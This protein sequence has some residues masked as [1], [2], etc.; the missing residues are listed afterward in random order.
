LK[1]DGATI[2]LASRVAGLLHVADHLL[3]LRRGQPPAFKAHA[4]V[5]NLLRPR[6]AAS[7]PEVAAGAPA[8]AEA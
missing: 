7:A 6:V 1:G 3:M 4:G 5:A 8:A 2:V